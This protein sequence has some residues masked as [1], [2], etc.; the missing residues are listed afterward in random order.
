MSNA[1]KRIAL[2]LAALLPALASAQGFPAKVIRIT[3]PYSSG[4]GP[5]LYAR[6]LSEQLSKTWGQQVIVEPRPGG[7][8]FIAIEAVKK[9]A[10]D[11]HEL[12]IVSNAHATINPALFKNV[13]YD[14][15]R[16]FVPI[17]M[18]YRTPFFVTVKSDGP[19]QTVQQLIAG[20]RAN[21]GKLIYGTPY[22]G[23]PAHLGSAWFESDTG[24]QMTHVPFKDTLQI[25]T[26][27]ANGDVT[28]SIATAAST[29]AMVKAGRVKLIAVAAK[30]RLATH[31][32][33]PTVE[34]AGGPR[35]FVVEAWLGLL[36]P[37]GTAR[38]VVRRINAD[39]L[40]TIDSPEMQKRYAALG[41]EPAPSTPEELA[42]LIRTDLGKNAELVKRTGAT[43]D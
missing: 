36:A 2:F 21:P 3:T 8:G 34:E 9:A 35:G 37:R 6:A 32:D 14:I 11:G 43:P 23:S 7:N 20:A 42:E 26:A 25:Y 4:S 15:E 27:I 5:D 10:P 31:Q 33:V 41:F 19:Y 40:R 24:T 38:E 1:I 29:S 22:V 16:D 39:T 18:L 30:T 12:L 17:V 28:W 13:P